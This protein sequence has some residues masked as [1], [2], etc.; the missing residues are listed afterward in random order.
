MNDEQI[1]SRIEMCVT[2]IMRRCY[3]LEDMGKNYPDFFTGERI[4]KIRNTLYQSVNGVIVNIYE[5]KQP[6]KPFKL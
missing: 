3:T 4:E 5:A 1:Q 6:K 2:V